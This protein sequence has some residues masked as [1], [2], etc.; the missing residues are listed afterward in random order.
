MNLHRTRAAGVLVV[1]GLALT[2]IDAQQRTRDEIPQALKWDLTDLY[3][4]DAAWGTA[5]EALEAE[6]SKPAAFRGTLTQSS[7]LEQALD[8]QA[9]QA[10][11]AARLGVYAH[12]AAD[13]DTRVA[14][15]QAMQQQMTQVFSAL[16][17]AWSFVEPELLGA[18][19]AFVERAL[20]EAPGLQ[21]FAFYLHDVERRRKHTLDT[22]Q[23]RLLAQYAPVAAGASDTS[24]ILL[25]A[26]LPW[27]T[28]KTSDGKEV[29]LDVSGFSLARMS[30]NRVDRQR[31]MEQFFGTLK[32]QP[33]PTA[34]YPI[35]VA[36]VASTFNEALLIDHMLKTVKDPKARLSLLGDYLEGVK[37]TV[38]RQTQFAEFELRAHEMAARGEPLTADTL[39]KL[40]LEITRKY[41]GHEAGVCIVDDYVGGEWAYIPQFY[42]PFYVY[43]YA[44]SFTASTALAQNV[45]QHQAGAV[46]RYRAFLASGGSAYPVDLL[47][48]AGVDMTTPAPLEATCT[49]DDR[50][51]GRNRADRALTSA[52]R[53]WWR[54]APRAGPGEGA[55]T[56]RE[57][58]KGGGSVSHR[59]FVEPWPLAA[60]PSSLARR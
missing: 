59:L 16:D 29:R 39:S 48:T 45:L 42:R 33:F 20:R 57:V 23:E 6:L 43:Q 55:A 31:S 27:P 34:Q 51:H 47:R 21:P 9:A 25:N 54:R 37:G 35:F 53:T 5:R 4:S 60:G 26:D 2:G 1:C 13:Q 24:G 52:S 15:Y 41:Y 18:D 30:A 40:Y 44:T 58:K 32:A 56:G 50:G 22:E 14:T 36:E 49:P 12:L 19:P 7:Q 3:P 8:L 28:M 17:A 46:D 38:F 11:T 10:K